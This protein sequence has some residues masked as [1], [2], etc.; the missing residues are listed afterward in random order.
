MKKL[1][2][3]HCIKFAESLAGKCLSLTYIN[4]D[5][6]MLWECKDGHQWIAT[7][8]HVQYNS[9][10][11]FE[12]K[13]KKHTIQECIEH[14]IKKDGKCL[15]TEIRSIKQKISWQCVKGH[16][17][18]ACFANMLT[19]DAWCDACSKNIFSID[20]CIEYAIL[21]GGKCLS[22][23]YNFGEKQKWQCG[24]C[25]LIWSKKFVLLKQNKYGW[26][27]RCARNGMR[28]TLQHCIDLAE[29]LNLEC[30]SKVYRNNKALMYWRCKK[31]DYKW[32]AAYSDL[33]RKKQKN[34][35]QCNYGISWAQKEIFLLLQDIF[36]T[37][38]IVLNDRETIK[39]M[40]IDVYIPSLK[41]GIE[42]DGDFWHYSDWAIS[43]KNSLEDMK[44][45]DE[46]TASADIML[47]RIRESKWEKD[48][49]LEL[50]IVIDAIYSALLLINSNYISSEENIINAKS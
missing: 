21:N 11:P 9:W 18:S 4:S 44:R 5:T 39:P 48:C 25:G 46:K 6:D 24:T 23:N 40:H 12:L 19:N 38:Y 41:I 7:Y 37:L 33:S 26:C 22:I 31:C 32:E 20:D 13:C 14:A 50:Q 17:W 27:S 1:G 34:C 8:R 15:S 35:S 2:I 43:I 29:R 28:L 45:K 36:P 30:L 47:F 16:I 10:C 49:E 3:A 42:Y